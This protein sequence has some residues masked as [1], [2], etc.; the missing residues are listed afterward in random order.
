LQ[1]IK[2]SITIL[3]ALGIL[4]ISSSAQAI[5]RNVGVMMTL[6]NP[7][8]GLQRAPVFNVG[9]VDVPTPTGGAYTQVGNPIE[10]PPNL[11]QVGPGTIYRTFAGIVYVAQLTFNYETT[12]GTAMLSPNNGAAA[13]APISFCPPVSGFVGGNTQCTFWEYPNNP[14]ATPPSNNRQAR[15]H[16]EPAGPS[17]AFG[18]V[19]EL[20]RNVTGQVW[21]LK[22][23]FPTPPLTGASAIASKNPR[24]VTQP[25]AG[26]LENYQYGTEPRGNGPN[27]PVSLDGNGVIQ[28]FL[29][30]PSCG[31]PP[32]NLGTPTS[33]MSPGTNWGFR[34][35]TGVVSGSD[36]SPP[37]NATTPFFFWAEQGQDTT[38][39]TTGGGTQRNLVLIGGG[40][41][42]S[43]ASGTPTMFN[44]ITKIRMVVPEPAMSSGL[45]AGLLLLGAAAWGRDRP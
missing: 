28:G 8:A 9:T 7:G 24:T 41:S 10:V 44:T 42:K 33:P 36:A 15:I 37:L 26:G 45:V 25:W 3:A 23:P 12:H 16:I 13:A 18:G 21:L 5:P 31:T 35:T 32:C 34:L 6:E 22:P 27:Y 14:T 17:N 11:M 1:S 30:T 38:S 43:P 40:I 4:A 29:T 20:M 2:T 19:L 39:M